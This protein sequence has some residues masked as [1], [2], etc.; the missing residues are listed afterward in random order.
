MVQN[1][2]ANR[3]RP[4]RTHVPATPASALGC[5]RILAVIGALALCTAQ[6]QARDNSTRTPDLV[7]VHPRFDSLGIQSVALLPATSFDKN[8]RGESLVESMFAKALQPAG[9]RWVT[10]FVS[11]ELIRSTAG[12]STMAAVSQGIVSAGRV[13]SLAAQ[14][15]CRTLRTTAVM[16]LRVDQFEQT[17]VDW[18]QSGKPTTTVRAR[19]ALVDSAGR[20]IWSASGSET[21]EGQYHEADASLTGVKSSGLST[22]PTTA[23]SGA[24][25]FEDVTTRMF[26]RWMRRFPARAGATVQASP[27]AK[28]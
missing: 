25:T 4:S 18:N 21:G 8:R 6:A 20:L 7:W 3:M 16:S 5:A 26:D 14:R 2:K 10:P 17:Q 15:L 19:A 1:G 27:G 24:P 9:Y 28:P 11:R 13:D 22:T 12:E 23:E